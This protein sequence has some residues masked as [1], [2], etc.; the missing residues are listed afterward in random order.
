[1]NQKQFNKW[2]DTFVEKKGIDIEQ[3]V[4][5]QGESGFN[6][7]PLGVVIEHM[8]IAN[9]AEQMLLYDRLVRLDFHNQPIVPF[10]E[11]LAQAIAK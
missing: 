4:E 2:L 1:M 6:E 8:K 9:A 5:V 10:L 3:V 11:H 7:I